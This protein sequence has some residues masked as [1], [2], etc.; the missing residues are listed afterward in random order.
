MVNKITIRLHNRIPWTWGTVACYYSP[1]YSG[2]WHR[3]FAWTQVLEAVMCYYGACEIILWSFKNY[4]FGLRTKNPMPIWIRQEMYVSGIILV[5][6][7]MYTICELWG[8]WLTRMHISYLK[9]QRDIHS[10]PF[11]YAMNTDLTMPDLFLI[12]R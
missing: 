11:W 3:M 7:H 5:Q 9:G 1:G 4:Y 2:D 8:L 12:K 10:Q 6:A